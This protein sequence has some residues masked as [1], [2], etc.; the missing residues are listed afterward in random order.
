ME[1]AEIKARIAEIARAQL[2]YAGEIPAGD[3]VESL[4]SLQTLQL[5]VAIEDEFQIS[6]EPD[7]DAGARTI[8]AVVATVA[9]LAA[10]RG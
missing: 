3:L 7:D 2:G 4:D 10:A 1:H 5:V 6:F 9:R 8:D